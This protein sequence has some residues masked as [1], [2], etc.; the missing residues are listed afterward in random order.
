MA[1]E[2]GSQTAPCRV[3]ELRA[4]GCPRSL[5]LGGVRQ[6]GAADQH[7]DDAH[8]E[9]SPAST[10]GGRRPGSPAGS[11]APAGGRAAPRARA[12]DQRRPRTAEHE[13]GRRR[14]SR[15]GSPGEFR[16]CAVAGE[17]GLGEDRHLG[18]VDG[19]EQPTASSS[20]DPDAEPEPVGERD[21]EEH[22]QPQTTSTSS[23]LASTTSSEAGSRDVV[24]PQRRL[25][26]C[27]A[28]TNAARSV[29]RSVTR[30]TVRRCAGPGARRRPGRPARGSAAPAVDGAS[31]VRSCRSRLARTDS[32][33]G[34]GL[35]TP[36]VG[37]CATRRS[38]CAGADC[39]WRLSVRLGT[40]GT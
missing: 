15:A 36:S 27:V 5:K 24:P 35:S 40:S 4:T 31:S 10:G 38:R 25:E 17:Q 16:N 34:R 13:L 19:R 1:C 23:G 29:A 32:N 30:R 3:V 7:D 9:R 2:N 26:D 12:H 11:D 20:H 33:V 28:H 22:D 21:H 8:D 14:P 39:R 18:D 37:V 6:Q